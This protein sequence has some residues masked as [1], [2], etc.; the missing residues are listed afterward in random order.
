MKKIMTKFNC[1]I[2]SLSLVAPAVFA[3]PGHDHAAQSANLIHLLWLAPV[4]IAAGYAAYKIFGNK[5]THR[6]KK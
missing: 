3:H 4:A 1:A 6:N 5:Q 2:A